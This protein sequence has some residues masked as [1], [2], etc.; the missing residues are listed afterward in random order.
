LVQDESVDHR[1]S[2]I[3][4]G[5][6]VEGRWLASERVTPLVNRHLFRFFRASGATSRR[7]RI[8]VVDLDDAVGPLLIAPGITPFAAS[9]QVRAQSQFTPLKSAATARENARGFLRQFLSGVREGGIAPTRHAY[10]H[11][12]RSAS[13]T[14]GRLPYVR[15]A[16]TSTASNRTSRSSLRGERQPLHGSHEHS[17]P[18]VAVW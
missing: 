7:S 9:T 8:R 16:Q 5:P 14:L 18:G 4:C 12:A 3:L 10:S 11:S 2:D 13:C 15:R 1:P 17:Q 6:V